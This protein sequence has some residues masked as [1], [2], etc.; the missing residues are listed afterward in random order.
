M[1]GE[2]ARDALVM[3]TWSRDLYMAVANFV[4]ECWAGFRHELDSMGVLPPCRKLSPI[5]PPLRMDEYHMMQRDKT[6]CENRFALSVP[7]SVL[8]CHPVILFHLVVFVDSLYRAAIKEAMVSL[9]MQLS[10]SVT[11]QQLQGGVQAV[12]QDPQHGVSGKESSL[13]CIIIGAGLGPLPD[14]CLTVAQEIGVDV[15]IHAVDANP[16]A[17][18]HMKIR[19]RKTSEVIVHDA[20]TLRPNHPLELLPPGL[21][22]LSRKCHIA[23][24][25]LLGCFGDDEFLPELTKTISTL[26][27]KP[28]YSISIPQSWTSYVCPV[29]ANS[30]HAAL[31][32]CKWPLDTTYV[33]GLTGDC[34]YLAEPVAVWSG[35][36]LASEPSPTEQREYS[37]DVTVMPSPFMVRQQKIIREYMNFKK[38]ENAVI[39]EAD[40]KPR[41][42]MEKGEYVVHGLLGY[43]TSC[44][45]GNIIIDSRHCSA[46]WN[47]FHW[48]CYFMPLPR[49]LPVR[50]TD[51][52]SIHLMRH[53][54]EAVKDGRG[55]CELSYSWSVKITCLPPV[56]ARCLENASIKPVTL[57]E[58][59][60]KGGKISI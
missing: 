6:K 59:V 39:T 22:E 24:S 60:K 35:T 44:L 1:T 42:N 48:E 57:F 36:C 52:L 46:D 19:F 25:E 21:R 4:Q 41:L 15:R 40:E 55:F 3:L 7:S 20:F 43:F 45:Y 33:A 13:N 54:T 9:R 30:V 26:F 17:I 29:Q 18:K 28:K 51:K 10:H 2:D 23:V 16:I 37:A 32:M 53:C 49:P 50:V 14:L 56:I 47:C 38:E 12:H 58:E 27:L 8:C 34:V 11:G 31:V 5:E